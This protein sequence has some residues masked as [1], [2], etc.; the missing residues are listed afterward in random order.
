MSCSIVT[1]E[2]G[3]QT[4]DIPELCG[5]NRAK[6]RGIVR[7][8][9]GKGLNANKAKPRSSTLAKERQTLKL[10][11][12]EQPLEDTPHEQLERGGAPWE[13]GRDLPATESSGIATKNTGELPSATLSTEKTSL[14]NEDMKAD[15]LLEA[16]GALAGQEPSPRAV[17]G[18]AGR[19]E[20]QASESLA[21]HADFADE[22]KLSQAV[23]D[24][25]RDPR[26]D[27]VGAA[28]GLDHACASRTAPRT[29][30]R[31]VQ[32]H[33]RC[34]R[35]EKRAFTS[36]SSRSR[37]S[38]SGNDSRSSRMSDSR[39]R[40]PSN[41]RRH[42]GSDSRRGMSPNS[43]RSESNGPTK[44]SNSQADPDITTMQ[45]VPYEAAFLVGKNHGAAVRNIARA[46]G[47]ETKLRHG[48]RTLDIRGGKRERNRAQKY[49]GFVLAQMERPVYLSD[50]DVDDDCSMV[51]VPDVAV[52]FVTGA[53]GTHLRRLEEEWG[54]IMMF[55]E[56][57]GTLITA[58]AGSGQVSRTETVVIFGP[59]RGRRGAQLTIMNVIES[60]LVNH[61]SQ[62][63]RL[64]GETY[65]G[66][67]VDNGGDF[68]TT[69]L[70]VREAVMP[71]ALGK[72]SGT[73]RKIMLASG[74]ILQYIGNFAVMS[75]TME[76]QLRAKD[77]LTWLLQTLDGPV[78][79]DRLDSR[80]D[81]TVVDVPGR[82]VGFIK[83]TRRESLSRHEEDWGVLMLFVG[84]HGQHGSPQ[85]DGIVTLLIFG[86]ERARKG[87]EIDVMCAME[88]KQSGF[89]TRFM[90]D[91]TSNFAGFDIEHKRMTEVEVSYALGVK[92]ETR[93]R[94]A[95]AS[96]A[97]IQFVGTV[98]CIAG[99]GQERQRCKDYLGWL[100]GRLRGESTI[101]CRGREDVTEIF[102]HGQGLNNKAMGIVTGKKGHTLQGVSKQTGT[103]CIVAKDHTGAERLCIF[104]HHVGSWLG[105]TGRRRAERMFRSVLKEAKAIVDA[106][107]GRWK[108]RRRDSSAGDRQDS[109]RADGRQGKHAS[110]GRTPSNTWPTSPNHNLRRTGS[111]WAA[112]PERWQQQRTMPY[113]KTCGIAHQRPPSWSAHSPY[114]RSPSHSTYPE[115]RNNR[116]NNQTWDRSRSKT[117]SVSLQ[118]YRSRCQSTWGHAEWR[119]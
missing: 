105:E 45:F 25:H 48:N 34:P 88:F 28:D 33:G 22:S 108:K 1:C 116:R 62:K 49:V 3:C 84:E 53:N 100:L 54:V 69:T 23:C 44:R 107:M 2:V 4:E 119:R 7:K 27:A 14:R 66:S 76:E 42:G 47:T 16:G 64:D 99:T 38:S 8:N 39:P 24:R 81:V 68:G 85:S 37:S 79:V 55:A 75:G 11:L 118:R 17:N 86:T 57:S 15:T 6:L 95:V 40:F 56:Y 13:E 71:Y 113:G 10:L 101:D 90:K 77:Y 63:I 112:S 97:I 94:L 67:D 26:L 58:V 65:H 5:L 51:S 83:G 106:E 91:K 103:W 21:A 78:H 60:K 41:D 98:C 80:S 102:V 73:R 46:T 50:K 72:N 20:A 93:K 115:F 29:R 74:C 18:S 61:F 31:E 110:A 104:G 111:R 70:E 59:C 9:K 32:R 89:C 52:G 36:S 92:G 109:W 43:Y 117:R 30:G 87:A 114:R 96:G 82:I 35:H 12:R 19:Q